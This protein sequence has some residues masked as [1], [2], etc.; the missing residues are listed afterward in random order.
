MGKKKGSKSRRLRPILERAISRGEIYCKTRNY[1]LDDERYLPDR[2]VY[3]VT[4]GRDVNW[5]MLNSREDIETVGVA[6]TIMEDGDI[7]Y[8]FTSG[9]NHMLNRE[10]A[11]WFKGKLL[12]IITLHK[13]GAFESNEEDR[14]SFERRKRFADMAS[15]KRSR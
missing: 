13:I 15:R 2:P 8:W 3:D 7:H 12:E 6:V 14:K 9:V 5:W 11:K 4:F 10:H 1:T